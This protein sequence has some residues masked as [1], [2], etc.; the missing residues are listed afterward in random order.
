MR[1]AGCCGRTMRANRM[2]PRPSG[3][4]RHR[5]GVPKPIPRLAHTAREVN[6]ESGMA[7]RYPRLG[8][9]SRSPARFGGQCDPPIAH[10][11]TEAPRL[12]PCRAGKQANA[13]G[14][15][16]DRG[17][18]HPWHQHQKERRGAG[19]RY[20]ITSS[21]RTPTIKGVTALGTRSGCPPPRRARSSTP[22][23]LANWCDLS[24][25]RD[26]LRPREGVSRRWFR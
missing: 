3:T 5:A 19:W 26:L 20:G 4:V 12:A 11:P 1:S 22:P 18:S 6:C 2:Q 13:P 24:C 25:P 16:R 8:R 21:S 10:R 7:G 14:R 17:R 15:S 23:T 9:S